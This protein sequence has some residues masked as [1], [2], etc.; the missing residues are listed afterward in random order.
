MLLILTA[1][2]LPLGMIA[3][4]ASIQS[5]HAKKLQREADTRIV[6]TS[7]ARQIDILL[8]RGTS[9]LRSTLALGELTDGQCRRHLRAEEQAFHAAVKVALFAPDGHLRCATPGFS[10]TSLSRPDQTTG[11]EVQLLD[12]PGSLRFAVAANDGSYAVGDLPDE[13]LAQILPSDDPTQG[14]VLAQGKQ[15]LRLSSS[16]RVFA[17]G[18]RVRVNVPIAGGQAQLQLTATTNPISAVEILLVLLPLLMW[19][20]AAGIGWIVVDQLLLRPLS[21]LQ[22]AVQAYGSGHGPLELP[23]VTTPAQ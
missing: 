17:L 9:L 11:T 5:A 7:E 2:L 4:A 8:L 12:A 19:A 21:Q 18:S 20:A 1:A 6:A 23:R 15:R 13:L 14:I 22:R 16:T 10:T 3:L